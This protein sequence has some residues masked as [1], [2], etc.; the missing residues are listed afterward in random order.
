M[1]SDITVVEM[2]QYPRISA[3]AERMT[4]AAPARGGGPCGTVSRS[5]ESLI[6]IV[7]MS[8]RFP[9]ARN[10]SQF[11]DN[12]RNGVESITRFSEAELEDSFSDEVRR[13]PN[14]VKAR[15]ILQD[16]DQF[17]ADFF[18]MYCARGRAHRSAAPGISRVRLGSAGKRR[19]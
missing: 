9:G 16:V 17:D 11:W 4:R 2:F 8:G 7:G 5:G 10:I 18:G 12:L 14:F 19:L 6:A 1:S 13:Q 15:P 3:L